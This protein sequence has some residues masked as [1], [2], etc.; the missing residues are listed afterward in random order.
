M[1]SIAL[2]RL[3]CLLFLAVAKSKLNEG[4]SFKNIMRTPLSRWSMHLYL[5]LSI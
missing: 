3:F 5:H 2:K 1:K 4:I